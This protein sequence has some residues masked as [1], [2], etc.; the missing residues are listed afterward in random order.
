[1]TD[2]VLMLGIYV[3][4]SH[5]V[6]WLKP[7]VGLSSG[8]LIKWIGYFSVILVLPELLAADDIY[9]RAFFYSSRIIYHGLS[10]IILRFCRRA[11]V[12]LPHILPNLKIWR[13]K[14]RKRIPGVTVI[15]QLVLLGGWPPPLKYQIEFFLGLLFLWSGLFLSVWII[16]S[17][18]LICGTGSTMWDP[19][20]FLDLISDQHF[21]NSNN[22][23]ENL[24]VLVSNSFSVINNLLP[25]IMLVIVLVCVLLNQ[26]TGASLLI[27]YTFNA[28]IRFIIWDPG[29]FLDYIPVVPTAIYSIQIHKCDKSPYLLYPINAYHTGNITVIIKINNLISNDVI[30][31]LSTSFANYGN[32]EQSYS[33]LG[34]S[35]VHYHP[36]QSF[37]S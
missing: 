30:Q 14:K 15:F 17:I 34:N 19:G 9:S 11:I 25:L 32:Q 1:M 37:V 5:F 12:L 36:F 2:L 26:L 35:F 18:G 31:L 10:S 6:K 28:G 22:Y 24:V 3:L 33:A 8:Y 23:G 27:A 4:I 20:L 21:D 29:L 7:Q 13:I 16:S